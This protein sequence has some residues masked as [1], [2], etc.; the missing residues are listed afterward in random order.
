MDV[1][2]TEIIIGIHSAITG[3]RPIILIGVFE[4]KE[5]AR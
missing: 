2:N 1:Y 3:R 4:E 5:L